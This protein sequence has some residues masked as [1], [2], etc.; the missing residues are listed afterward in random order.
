MLTKKKGLI[1]M[2]TERIGVP[3]PL[4][5]EFFDAQDGD[6]DEEDVELALSDDIT[7]P[8]EPEKAE[9]IMEGRL[10]CTSERAEL[11][12]EE[13]ELTGME[14]A[15][16]KIGFSHRYPELISMLRSGSVDTA[17]VFEPRQRHICV[18][19]TPF[20]SFEVCVQGITVRNT[21][22]ENGSLHLDYLIEI[23][24][25]RTERCRMWIEFRESESTETK[26]K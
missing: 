5:S 1:V 22:L 23:R 6:A 18:Y 9:M 10:I 17:L 11:I 4:F 13:S 15:T 26:K 7:E 19:N 14:G 12:W 8:G 3:V 21:L 2:R 20:S 25:N 16:S 24:G